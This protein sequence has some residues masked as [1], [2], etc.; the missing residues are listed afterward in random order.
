[1]VE[2]EEDVDIGDQDVHPFEEDLPFAEDL[3]LREEDH[4]HLEGPLDLQEEDHLTGQDLPPHVEDH[5]PQQEV[6]LQCAEEADPILREA[7]IDQ[8]EE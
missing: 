6:D 7:E 2:D 5:V 4:L 1:M 3:H 8:V